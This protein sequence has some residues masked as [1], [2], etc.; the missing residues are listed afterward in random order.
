MKIFILYLVICITIP[1]ANAFSPPAFGLGALFRPPNIKIIKSE[2]DADR[3]E[4]AGKFFV[5][6]FWRG[7]VGG[8][9]TLSQKQAYQLERQQVAEFNKRYRRRGAVIQSGRLPGNYAGRSYDSSAELV[10]CVNGSGDVIGCAGVEGEITDIVRIA[11]VYHIY[12][13]YLTRY[14]SV[15][16]NN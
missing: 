9:T 13:I 7:K 16:F 12:C 5:D 14:C 8:A 4:E 2:G 15:F 3:L 11:S 10:L 6:A 1:I